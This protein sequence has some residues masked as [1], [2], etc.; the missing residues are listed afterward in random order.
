MFPYA[1]P[2]SLNYLAASLRK[3]L[4]QDAMVHVVQC[5]KHGIR[6]W[7]THDGVDNGGSRVAEEVRRVVKSHGNALEKISFIGFSQIGRAH[8]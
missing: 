4:N 8:V 3:D 6:H 7:R 1:G 2:S 5:N